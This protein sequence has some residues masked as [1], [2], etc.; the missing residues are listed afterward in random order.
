[1]C[2][3][4]CPKDFPF[5]FHDV[6]DGEIAVMTEVWKFRCVWGWPAK[7]LLAVVLLS[8]RCGMADVCQH[9]S[10]LS[11]SSAQFW[12]LL[13]FLIKFP[14]SRPVLKLVYGVLEWLP[15]RRGVAWRGVFL[16]CGISM[17]FFFWLASK[18]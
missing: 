7:C 3:L 13:T 16:L 18:T 6:G 11:S 8:P 15:R 5:T 1:M 12:V 17:G 4:S 10:P 2:L 14:A 9:S